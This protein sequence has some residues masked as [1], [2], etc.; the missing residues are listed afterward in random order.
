MSVLAM[1]RALGLRDL[2]DEIVSWLPEAGLAATMRVNRLWFEASKRVLWN[3]VD[4]RDAL[5]LLGPHESLY[6]NIHVCKSSHPDSASCTL[7]QCFLTF[8]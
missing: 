5:Q 6:K 7:P 1:Q 3:A 4:P 8:L 2:V